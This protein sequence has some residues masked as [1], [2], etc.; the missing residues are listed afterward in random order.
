MYIFKYFF[1]LYLRY[2]KFLCLPCIIRGIMGG[3][4]KI[5][6]NR[7]RSAEI[8]SKQIFETIH[9]FWATLYLQESELG[10]KICFRYNNYSGMY[11]AKNK[12]KIVPRRSSKVIIQSQGH[13]VLVWV[14]SSQEYQTQTKKK[15][16][17]FPQNSLSQTYHKSCT[18]T[19]QYVMLLP[20]K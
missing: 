17:S 10:N 9:F 15:K 8:Q 14:E 6:K 16:K 2:S 5:L 11:Q 20:I 1:T 19:A 18:I 7:C 3:R 12:Q 13:T 4:H